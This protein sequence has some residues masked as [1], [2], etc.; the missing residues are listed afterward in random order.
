[1][2]RKL[3]ITSTGFCNTGSSAVTHILSEFD[4]V[5]NST[6]VYEIRLLYD[7]DSI[8][9][10]EHNLVEMPHRQNSSYAVR[11]FIRY[12]KFNSNPLLNHHY[13]KMC[14]GM[15]RKITQSYIRDLLLF[16][17]KAQTFI[18]VWDKGSLVWFLDRVYMKLIKVL[19]RQRFTNIIPSS[20][21]KA[22]RQYACTCDKSHF[23]RATK[24]YIGEFLDF[25]RKG[26]DIVLI[27]QFFPATNISKYIQYIP[28][29]YE[30]KAFIVDRDPRDLYVMFKKLLNTTGVPC[31]DVRIFCD[32]VRWTR[33][34]SQIKPDPE[35]VKRIQFEDLIYNYEETRNRILEFCGFSELSCGYKGKIFRPMI[36][37]NNTQS[38]LRYPDLANDIKYIEA[39]L[40]N[41]CYDF[42]SK[43]IK[44]DFEN[45]KMF[46]C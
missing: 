45:G 44:P 30:I 23:L 17:Y 46:D 2:S 15:F 7:P 18:D 37:I 41:Y 33:E 19:F 38:W 34:Q 13:E 14:S 10:L 16:D 4:D 5:V 25:I 24:K 43:S 36:S 31:Y 26:N 29:E 22:Q 28:D 12:I 39:T 20:I 40:P 1:M 32:W 42:E 6:G 35:C 3:L 21:I 11:R 27:D 8:S 9:D